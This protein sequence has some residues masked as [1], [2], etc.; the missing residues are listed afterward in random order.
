M[1]E[2]PDGHEQAIQIGVW[3]PSEGLP[4]ERANAAGQR[5]AINS[6]VMGG[7]H[8]LVIISPGN[9]AG[10]EAHADTAFAL[11]EA[12]YIVASI[13]HTG[14]TVGQKTSR[15]SK[16]MIDRPRHVRR[17]IDYLLEAWP[18]RSKIAA[19][20]IGMFGFS[21][22]GFTALVTAGG[23]PNLRLASQFCNRSKGELACRLAMTRDFSSKMVASRANDPWVSDP[24]VRAVVVA[25]PGLGFSFD[26]E[27]LK[28]VQVPVQL[29]AASDDRNAPIA[30]NA[31]IVQKNLPHPPEVHVVEGV[32][33]F[34][35]SRPCN[36]KRE[37]Q[38]KRS[39]VSPTNFTQEEFHQVFNNKI[40]Q[41]FDLSLPQ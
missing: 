36:P 40:M 31:L 3:Y 9:G 18:E 15:P 11:A 19:T 33:H 4:S 1:L 22:G 2:V 17:T 29:W 20:R 38:R 27:A 7:V 28:D 35:F 21:A 8:P 39:C 37:P 16:W 23:H 34:I 5:L 14:D 24:R 30:S 12:G 13:A 10:I 41:F 6:Q 32:G 25:S 26:K